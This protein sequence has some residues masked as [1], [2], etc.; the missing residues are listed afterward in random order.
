MDGKTKKTY[1]VGKPPIFGSHAGVDALRRAGRMKVSS[2]SCFRIQ[3][4]EKVWWVVRVKMESPLSPYLKSSSGE[5]A[6][7]ILKTK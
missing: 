3:R 2:I 5:P 6:M 7:K 4:G 1:E